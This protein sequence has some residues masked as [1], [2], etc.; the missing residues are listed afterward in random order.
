MIMDKKHF[1]EIINTLIAIRGNLTRVR[2]FEYEIDNVNN[3]DKTLI[4]YYLCN[5]YSDFNCLKSI[6]YTNSYSMSEIDDF[7]EE[8]KKF[9][10][11]ADPYIAG[12]ENIYS[13]L[14]SCKEIVDIIN[15]LEESFRNKLR[16]IL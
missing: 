9:Y 10:N 8:Y 16:N 12:V 14:N 3:I 1:Q 5:A 15:E 4:M 13:L 2:L 6:Y 11:E 7:I